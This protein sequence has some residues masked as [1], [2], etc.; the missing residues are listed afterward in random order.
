MLIVNSFVKNKNWG[1]GGGG[2]LINFPPLKRG[3]LLEKG[4][5][6][7][8]EGFIEDLR[9]CQNYF[10]GL[11]VLFSSVFVRRRT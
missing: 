8:R 4:G 6:F 11:C 9:Y 10:L 2:G 1:G 7:K 5:L 3:D